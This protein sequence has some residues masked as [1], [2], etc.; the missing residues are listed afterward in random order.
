MKFQYAH[1][2]NFRTVLIRK[3][4]DLSVASV[5]QPITAVRSATGADSLHKR[6]SIVASSISTL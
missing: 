2:R 3:K 4:G 6:Y 1:E 5:F